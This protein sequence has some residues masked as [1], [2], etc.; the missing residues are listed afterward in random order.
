MLISATIPLISVMAPKD[1]DPKKS[2]QDIP[3]NRF[4][5]YRTMS[6]KY[7]SGFYSVVVHF[8]FCEVAGKARFGIIIALSMDVDALQQQQELNRKCRMQIS[9]KHPAAEPCSRPVQQL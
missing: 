5:K 2:I 1:K 9:K 4:Y 8:K 7:R 6:C 3:E